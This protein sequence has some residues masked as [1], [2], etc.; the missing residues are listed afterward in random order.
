[1]LETMLIHRDTLQID[2][3]TLSPSPVRRRDHTLVLD[4]RRRRALMY[5]GA[6]ESDHV[7]DDVWA[8]QLP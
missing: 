7:F 3:P 4:T 1:M 8:L 5:G 6:F 2:E